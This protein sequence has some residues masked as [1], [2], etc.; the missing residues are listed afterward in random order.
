[1]DEKQWYI[2]LF[3]IKP[4]EVKPVLY[5][6]VFSF[7]IGLSMTFYFAA[8][9]AIFIQHFEPHMIPI[10]YVVSGVVVWIAWW[11]LSRLDHKL[12]IQW[13]L[14]LKFIFLFVTVT[15]ISIGVWFLKAPWIIFLM[16]T[17][18]RVLVYITLVTFWGLAGRMF[19]IQQG[20]R[21]FGLLGVGE[22]VSIIIGYFSVPLLLNYI[23]TPDLLI[24]SSASLFVC[25]ALVL[26]MLNV[27]GDML[28]DKQ[29]PD[30]KGQTG[31]VKNKTSYWQMVKEPYYFLISLMALIP[32][33]GYLFIDF[34][35]LAQTKIEFANN[36]ET[37]AKFL[38][39][40]LGVVAII[41]LLF[42]LISGWLLNRFGLKTGLVILPFILFTGV[43]LAAI[44][45][46]IYGTAGLFF[47]FIAMAR[48]FE[49]S[50]RAGV[51][52]PSFQLLYQPVPKS[53]R[54]VFQNQIEGIP[55][56][57]GTVI[58]GFI[59]LLFSVF[60]FFSLVHY[61]WMLAG[62]LVVWLWIA[63]KMYDH[64]RQMLKAKLAELKSDSIQNA[65]FDASV[66]QKNISTINDDHIKKLLEKAD[67]DVREVM[68]LLRSNM[69]HTDSAVRR[70]MH[71]TLGH[72]GYTASSDEVAKIRSYINETTENALWIQASL[73]DI[74]N[75]V[76]SDGL[77]RDLLDQ[78]AAEKEYIFVLL[79][80][81]YE[82]NTIGHIKEYLESTDA[83]AKVY[84]Y[85]MSE[86]LFDDELKQHFF[87]LFND[88]GFKERLQHFHEVFPQEQ[89]NPG[90]RL[91]DIL[92]REAS[93]VWISTKASALN[94]IDKQPQLTSNAIK[95][96]LA[97]FM[98][99]PE[100]SLAE[101]AA[102]KLQNC[103]PDFYKEVSAR[104]KHT[105]AAYLTDLPEANAKGSAN[106]HP[107]DTT[108][109]I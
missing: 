7:F 66:I 71:I 16:F 65:P 45:G 103:Y 76:D 64:Y 12:S 42:K 88:M 101:R 38:G 10:S 60:Q 75:A 61:S 67:T 13:Q 48:L 81:L 109:R 18:I 47:A 79:S 2:S 108:R 54:L 97:A 94:I 23:T 27:F 14:I 8:S 106:D 70:T 11:S 107:Y 91:L 32:I 55:K 19:N 62:V 105:S 104:F 100:P 25:L 56:A 6:V 17:W 93:K 26:L 59:I 86:I 92:N 41:E 57:S 15:A 3:G 46:T 85:E 40:F 90:Y 44:A 69:F 4:V 96:I 31:T 28:S 51:Y 29:T 72:L 82:T 35:F 24:L 5:L 87:S 73:L 30:Q 95:T 83:N 98:V 22:V 63:I 37:I 36:P 74:E 1:M 20:K 78:L 34:L 99:H 53:N 49:R 50:V 43:L 21:V 102:K 58:T 84:A 89:M 33:F 68:E 9:N 77:Q 39:A 52:E 80:L